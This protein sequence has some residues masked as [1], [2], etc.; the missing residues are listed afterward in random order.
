ME[1]EQQNLDIKLGDTYVRAH[2]IVFVSKYLF[3]NTLEIFHGKFMSEPQN[4][5]Q[6]IIPMCVCI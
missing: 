2:H 5:T 4:Y 3:Q 1:Q 6:S